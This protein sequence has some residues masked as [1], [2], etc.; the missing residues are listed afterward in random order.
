MADS[1]SVARVDFVFAMN[2]NPEPVTEFPYKLN[3]QHYPNC[4]KQFK[5]LTNPFMNV[6]V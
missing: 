5:V 3:I 4:I 1:D 2:S 6:S